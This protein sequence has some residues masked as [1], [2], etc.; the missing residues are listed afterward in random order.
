MTRMFL[1]MGQC[2]FDDNYVCH[3]Y[4]WYKL[5]QQNSITAVIPVF[6]VTRD[7]RTRTLCGEP[8]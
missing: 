8:E 5:T 3:A 4:L 2:P 1:L 7:T 6:P